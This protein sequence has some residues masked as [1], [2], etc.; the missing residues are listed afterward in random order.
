MDK[1]IIT[2]KIDLAKKIIFGGDSRGSFSTV[3]FYDL[4]DNSVNICVSSQ[5]GCVERCAF[6]ATG[7]APFVRNLS[8]D[9][10]VEQLSEGVRV[11]QDLAEEKDP[12]ILYI[13][14]EGMGEATFNLGNCLNGFKQ[15]YDSGDNIFKNIAFRISTA[16]NP[17]FIEPYKSFIER[18]REHMGNVRFQFQLSLHS[19]FDD[20][21]SQIIPY[22]GKK[23]PI[24]D[25]TRKMQELADYLGTKLKFNYMLLNFPKGGTNYTNRHQEALAELAV[26]RNARIK[27]TKY[28]D[29]GKGFSSPGDSAYASVKSFLESRGIRVSL[30]PLFGSDIQ[31]ACGMLDYRK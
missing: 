13:I 18:N 10:I 1:R 5:V 24:E 15:F 12:R 28:S 19:P 29:T 25:T 23:Y 6:C 16:G 7:D 8:L 9:D 4:D 31:A 14:F 20:E 3:S 2:S 11:M 17:D 22:L 21:R 27:L 30:R 26:R